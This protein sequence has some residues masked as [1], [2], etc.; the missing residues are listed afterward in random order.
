VIFCVFD[1][2]VIILLFCA[3][4]FICK[5]E[6]FVFCV[7]TEVC[8]FVI[9][10]FCAV[11]E[12][13]KFVIAVFCVVSDVCKFEIEFCKLVIFVWFVDICVFN[14]SVNADDCVSK[15]LKVLSV[16]NNKFENLP[17]AF[18]VVE[19]IFNEFVDKM[20]SPIPLFKIILLV[21]FPLIYKLLSDVFVGPISP[22]F[23]NASVIPPRRN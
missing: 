13:C 22:Q 8:K 4:S 5:F 21:E 3:V 11:S 12:F 9:A 14:V 16:E 18:A 23:I 6:I 10:V 17:F 1:C 2:N 15:L 20:T 19:P 7:A